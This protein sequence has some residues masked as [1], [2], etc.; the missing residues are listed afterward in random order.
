LIV[1]LRGILRE[2]KPPT[3]WIDV[4]GIGYGVQVSLSTY[5]V[6]PEP[7]RETELFTTLVVR[8]DS[9]QLYGFATR[10]ERKLFDLLLT[11]SGVG[12]RGALGILSGLRPEAF[13]RSVSDGDVA[14]LTA[15]SGV[16]KKTAERILVELRDKVSTDKTLT[17]GPVLSTLHQDAVTALIALG[18]TPQKAQKSVRSAAAALP[19]NTGL[20]EIV[21]R[22]LAESSRS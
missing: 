8:E 21:R 16:G 7:G 11:V 18:F 19:A 3:A 17:A 14:A 15:I 13:V 1:S 5:E 12:P 10:E 20:E 22:A 2:K 6:L 4:N 9:Q